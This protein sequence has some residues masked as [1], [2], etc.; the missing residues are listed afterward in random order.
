MMEE[1]KSGL[2]IGLFLTGLF[3]FATSG[4]TLYY[5]LTNGNMARKVG[6]MTYAEFVLVACFFVGAYITTN[7]LKKNRNYDN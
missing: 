7:V 6:E 1:I 2:R 3:L 5:Q 4:F